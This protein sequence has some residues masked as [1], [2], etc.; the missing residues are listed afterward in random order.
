MKY[1]RLISKIAMAL[2]T[3]RDL[4]KLTEEDAVSNQC[5]FMWRQRH[6]N[7]DLFSVIL[8]CIAKYDFNN[9]NIAP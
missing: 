1:F 2:S 7:S 5:E 9:E 4:F 6:M 3:L 8:N